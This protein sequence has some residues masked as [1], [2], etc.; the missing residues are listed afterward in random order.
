MAV[1]RGDAVVV[2]TETAASR[3]DTLVAYFL[4]DA[5]AGRRRATPAAAAARRP[6]H[7]GRRRGSKIERVEAFGNVEIRT[8]DEVVRGDRGVYSPAPAWRGCSAN[9]RI[10][11]GDN[12]LNGQEAIVNLQTGVARLVSAPGAARAG[13]GRAAAARRP[14]SSRGAPR[15]HSSRQP[16]PPSAA[17]DAAMPPERR[18]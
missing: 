7:A 5:A 2:T 14:R 3:A 8:A 12:Q 1:A 16:A 13:P 18:R 17:G 15:S 4:E 9:V 10:T 11:R 6:A